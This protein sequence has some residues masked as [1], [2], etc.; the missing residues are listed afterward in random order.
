MKSELPEVAYTIDRMQWWPDAWK[1]APEK[2]HVSVNG[3]ELIEER[4]QPLIA[5]AGKRARIGN[6]TTTVSAARS[7]TGWQALVTR[8]S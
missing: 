7:V 3:A 1:L 8:D 6:W 4:A 2:G 5:S